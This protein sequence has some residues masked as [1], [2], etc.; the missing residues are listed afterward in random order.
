MIVSPPDENVPPT[1]E[2]FKIASVMR[3]CCSLR[4]FVLLPVLPSALVYD[5]G[6]YENF[7]HPN[8]GKEQTGEK[9]NRKYRG[10]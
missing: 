2:R 4:S 1:T 9:E 10:E 6:T 3:V 8:T 5:E 7:A